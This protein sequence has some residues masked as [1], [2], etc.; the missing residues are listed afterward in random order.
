LDFLRLKRLKK[1]TVF[2]GVALSFYLTIGGVEKAILCFGSDGRLQLE[3]IMDVSCNQVNPQAPSSALES[4]L[5]FCLSSPS[6]G[7]NC[8]P[9]T[10][11]PLSITDALHLS[12]PHPNIL[13]SQPPLAQ[14]LPV[15]MP[16]CT[17]TLDASRFSEQWPAPSGQTLATLSSVVLLI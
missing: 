17:Q 13:I 15:L 5:S 9:C 7:D 2:F 4:P 1:F 3:F 8:G 6:S 10:D 14:L 16:E 12:A 11:I